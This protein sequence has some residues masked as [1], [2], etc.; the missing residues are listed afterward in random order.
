MESMEQQTNG[1]E[2]NPRDFAQ[3]VESKAKESLENGASLTL[4]GTEKPVRLE[5]FSDSLRVELQEK[6]KIA[7]R[8]YDDLPDPIRSEEDWRTR[9][10]VAKLVKFYQAQEEFFSWLTEAK[11]DPNLSELAPLLWGEI[12]KTYATCLKEFPNN[13]PKE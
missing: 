13:P 12:Q 1:A 4:N 9:Q 2:M 11:D 8:M 3:E 5:N 7:K 10:S 6:A